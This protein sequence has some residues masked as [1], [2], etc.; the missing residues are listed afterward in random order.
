[1]TLSETDII[2]RYFLNTPDNDSAARSHSTVAI[3]IGDDAAAVRVPAG[4]E[5]LSA[6]DTIVEGVHFPV[7]FAAADIGYRVLAV[8]LSDLAAMGAKPAWALLSLSMPHVEESWLE[9]FCE[10]FFSLAR[11]HD[12]ALIGGDLV[13]GPLAATVTILGLSP[14]RSAITRGG[15]AAGDAVYVT[16]SPG[17]AALGLQSLMHPDSGSSHYEPF[18]R[19]PRPRVAEGI[20]LRGIASAM[21][22][23]SDGLLKD[24]G[25]IAAASAV[26][27]RFDAE[28]IGRAGGGGLR[29]ALTGGDDYDLCFTVSAD[30]RDELAVITAQWDCAAHRI[31]DVGHGSGVVV[32]GHNLDTLKGFDHFAHDRRSETGI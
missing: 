16:G 7:R 3:G 24:A 1:M 18:F 11:R 4:M 31:G 22:D 2:R 10:G 28:A 13:K 19:R 21:I 30:K 25:R 6:I 8:N 17:A 32:P 9:S 20:S 27:I 15:A 5:L 12:V 29:A 14:A 26:Q 23:T